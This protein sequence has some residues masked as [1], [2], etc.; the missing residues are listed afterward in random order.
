MAGAYSILV[1]HVW[2]GN[3]SRWVLKLAVMILLSGLFIDL[4]AAGY[5]LMLHYGND[6]L[7]SIWMIAFGSGGYD[8]MQAMVH[9]YL[10]MKY[11]DTARKI[12]AKFKGDPEPQETAF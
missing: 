2:N 9:Y 3:R 10:A 7:L 1:R 12:P 6:G 5:I 11:R 4:L 8:G